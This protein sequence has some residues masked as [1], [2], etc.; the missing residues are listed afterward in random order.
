MEVCFL[1]LVQIFKLVACVLRIELDLLAWFEDVLSRLEDLL[2]LLE[3]SSN[4]FLAMA[5][6]SIAPILSLSLLKINC[7]NR[8][9]GPS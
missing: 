7:I 3:L 5:C 8:V 6:D 9:N 4:F 1:L 2:D